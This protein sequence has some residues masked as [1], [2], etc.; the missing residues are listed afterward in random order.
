MKRKKFKLKR[1][2]WFKC[3]QCKHKFIRKVY[4]YEEV[5]CPK[6]IE[7]GID[8]YADEQK[9]KHESFDI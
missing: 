5:I 4:D 2:V 3:G 7:F 6:C 9:S 1:F 8:V